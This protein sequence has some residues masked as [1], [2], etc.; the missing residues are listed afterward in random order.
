MGYR[1]DP[2]DS[3]S[4]ESGVKLDEADY[5]GKMSPEVFHGWVAS[6]HHF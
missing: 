3:T 1:F 5:H 6:S 2:G 4:R